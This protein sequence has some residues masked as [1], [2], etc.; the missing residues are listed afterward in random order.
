MSDCGVCLYSDDNSDISFS[1]VEFVRARKPY[2]CS[3]CG[4]PIIAGQRHEVASG[5]CEGE[6]WR[7]RTCLVCAEIAEAF[8]CNG[9]T[10]GGILWDFMDDVWGELTTSCFDRLK[11]PQAKAEL[12]RRWIEW[13]LDQ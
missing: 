6:F 8:F 2:K 7:Y 12:Q 1:D 9:R 11:T 13:K 4:A 3:E 10:F 5:R